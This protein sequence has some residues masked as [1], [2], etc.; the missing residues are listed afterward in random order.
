[1]SESAWTCIK[2]IVLAA[3]AAVVTIATAYIAA[4]W[5]LGRVARNNRKPDSEPDVK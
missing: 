2:D 1:M 3:I 4:R 5:N